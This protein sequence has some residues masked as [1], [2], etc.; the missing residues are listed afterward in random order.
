MQRLAVKTP[1]VLQTAHREFRGISGDSHRYVSGVLSEIINAERDCYTIAI[2]RKVEVGFDRC[3][4]PALSLPPV[5]S[6][7]HL[8]FRIDADDRLSFLKKSGFQTGNIS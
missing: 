2:P 8:L 1:P 3:S 6:D 4:P 7:L 5:V